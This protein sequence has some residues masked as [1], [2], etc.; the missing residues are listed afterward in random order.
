MLTVILGGAGS[1]K[2]RYALQLARES[3]DSVV[4]I[5]TCVP[6]DEEMR[7]KVARHKR[8]RPAG[9]TT[10]EAPL[11]LTAVL[12]EHQRG[13]RVL[14]LDCLTLY[15]S[16]ALIKGASKSSTLEGLERFCR[17]ALLSPM[18]VIVV[19]N[20]VGLG[21]V[22]ESALGRGFRDL[23]GS[24][25]QLVASLAH[26]V[27]FVVAGIALPLKRADSAGRNL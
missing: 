27:F 12:T 17:Q 26:E 2:S 15:L 11:D 9:W 1:G 10:V 7:D 21:I 19:S 23:A 6:R 25:N 14:L 18:H 16:E 24:A 20:E 8:E 4:F 3:G 13:S 5:A 22:P